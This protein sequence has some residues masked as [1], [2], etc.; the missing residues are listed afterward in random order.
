MFLHTR[1]RMSPWEF[2]AIELEFS[3]FFEMAI[4]GCADQ[5]LCE[6][7]TIEFTEAVDPSRYGKLN[8]CSKGI[9]EHC[10]HDKK[11]RICAR[12]A[13]QVL[14]IQQRILSF[15]LDCALEILHD[16]TETE[17]LRSPVLDAP[18]SI[19]PYEAAQSQQTSFTSVLN[20]A[21]YRGWSSLD[22]SKLRGYIESTLAKHKSHVWALREDPGYFADTIRESLDHHAA[23]VPADCG[24]HLKQWK[25]HP[26]LKKG[27][28][29][30]MLHEA[31]H[32]VHN[33]TYLKDRL[34]VFERL[35][36]EGASKHQQARVIVEFREMT[37]IITSSL[38][39][40][41]E[42][43]YRAA[44]GCRMLFTKA[45]ETDT[46]R[47][48]PG[49]DSNQAV[50][51]SVMGLFR[52]MI[53][54]DTGAGIHC[55]TLFMLPWHLEVLDQILQK[56]QTAR[57]MVTGRILDL[58]TDLS[59]ITECDRQ[60]SLWSKSPDVQTGE[61]DACGCNFVVEDPDGMNFYDWE[62]ALNQDFTPPLVTVYPL[63]DKLSYP[64]HKKRTR[65]TTTI[66]CK[67]EYNL[68]LFWAVVDN[69]F[70][71]KTGLA[72]HRVIKNCLL[73]S[74][75]MHRTIPWNDVAAQ[76]SK[77]V[78]SIVTEYQP[79]SSHL[80][81]EALQ[82]T[83]TFDRM[84]VINKAKPKT[85]GTDALEPKN[86]SVASVQSVGLATF[87]EEPNFK[88][89]KQTYKVFRAILHV[90]SVDAEEVAR[91]VKWADF[92]KAMG[93]M[94]FAVEK[95]Q[96]S[97]WQFIPSTDIGN[98]RNIQFHEPHPANDITPVIAS[99]MGRRLSRVYGWSGDMFTLA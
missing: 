11:Y 27:L 1:G 59:I 81:D 24:L 53:D 61:V 92:I 84:S 78:Q 32:M 97:A 2:A 26:S 37:Q 72:Q 8:R 20:L 75:R 48:V 39:S 51:L 64:E 80:H 46:Y 3:P 65:N 95:L 29:L 44:P 69:H 50:Y 56:S 62:D 9:D 96:G 25:E 41:V 15:L 87:D 13:F 60:T 89:K 49:I 4:K 67:A 63:K 12:R 47:R 22:F 28:I 17:L 68:D 10:E 34:D 31:Y 19:Q 36:E 93:D 6:T 33:W 7:L 66:M 73:D 18:P 86:F 82:I 23:N 58:L 54:E 38:I 55:D 14:L 94:G 90:P 52:G 43:S 85:K 71:E 5:T 83:G 30:R 98:E 79:I 21:P 99:R 74:H 91:Q 57:G 77:P 45:C 76:I 42:N 16:K 35:L 88:V 40:K 70:R